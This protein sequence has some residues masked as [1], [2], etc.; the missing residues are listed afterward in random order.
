MSSILKALKKLEQ[1]KSIRE[2]GGGG[3]AVD[4]RTHVENPHGRPSQRFS[5]IAAFLVLVSVAVLAALSYRWYET[6]KPATGP[7]VTTRAVHV[8]SSFVP[9]PHPIKEETGA[10]P[11]EKTTVAEP[12]KRNI[13][14]G[15]S[16]TQPAPIVRSERPLPKSTPLRLAP[17][18]ETGQKA[19]VVPMP[20]PSGIGPVPLGAGAQKTLPA[21]VPVGPTLAV[22]GIAW[23]K[24]SADRLAIVNGQPLAVGAAIGGITIKEIL[25]DR[26]RFAHNGKTFEVMLGGTG[27]VP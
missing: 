13:P 22:S 5:V 12:S 10:P 14:S 6:V 23:Q 21:P 17:H 2:Q 18:G 3:G 24:D 15:R 19:G 16:V 7:S 1:E 20:A 8:P 25:P 11:Q 26:V 4:G 9:E 27:T